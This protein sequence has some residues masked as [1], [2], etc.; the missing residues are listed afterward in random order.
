[1]KGLAITCVN[2]ATKEWTIYD[3]RYKTFYYLTHAEFKDLLENKPVKLKG[4][5]INANSREKI[6]IDGLVNSEWF[7]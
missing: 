6:W 7:K 1:M 5:F 2:N 3:A 4:C